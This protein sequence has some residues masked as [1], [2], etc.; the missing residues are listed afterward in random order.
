MMTPHDFADDFIFVWEDGSSDDPNK[1]HS[2]NRAD[3]GNWVGS[4]LVGSNHGVT[5]MALAIWRRVSVNSI[6]YDVM[7]ALQREEAAMIAVYDYYHMS[8]LDQMTWNALTASAFDFAYNASPKTAVTS[9]QNL[10]GVKP[11]NDLGM[12]SQRSFDAYIN[13]NGLDAAAV[14]WAHE[15]NDY[16]DAVISAHPNDAQFRNGW[17]KRSMYYTPS[18]AGWW[19]RF[20][21]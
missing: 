16:Y 13:T 17:Y 18:N 4:T 9:L 14:L 5:P 2:M 7:H 6:T 12:I 8:G 21:A 1:T 15:R 20:N 11:D 10:I 3:G 19:L